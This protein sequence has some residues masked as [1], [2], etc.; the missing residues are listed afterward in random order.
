MIYFAARGP[1][2][3]RVLS[4]MHLTHLRL[5]GR[6][7]R[8]GEHAYQWAK[9][10]YFGFHRLARETTHIQDP[11][12]VKRR[13][14][15]A[16]TY[17]QT[18]RWR[19]DV[20]NG[21]TR[22]MTQVINAKYDQCRNFRNICERLPYAIFCEAT[23]D[24]FWGVGATVGEVRT[25]PYAHLEEMPGRNVLGRII[26]MVALGRVGAPDHVIQTVRGM[27][28]MPVAVMRVRGRAPRPDP[29]PRAYA[30]QLLTPDNRE[31]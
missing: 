8:S 23:R 1:P 28:P 25:H 19:A 11:F 31:G 2:V 21:A 5:W 6:R 15:N 13:V 16:F 3:Y 27:E 29:R 26:T 24:V 20:Q 17:Q 9:C 7:F 22:V 4:N 30:T 18:L 14:R 12:A 10:K